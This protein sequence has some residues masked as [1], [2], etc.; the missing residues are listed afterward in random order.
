M[1]YVV[2]EIGVI[3]NH[4]HYLMP[5]IFDLVHS[6]QNKVQEIFGGRPKRFVDDFCSI[7][8]GVAPYAFRS[9]TVLVIMDARFPYIHFCIIIRIDETPAS[10]MMIMWAC[11]DAANFDFVEK[12]ALSLRRHS[13]N[14][15]QFCGISEWSA[16]VNPPWVF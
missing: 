3:V 7:K 1:T 6:H 15:R 12:A 4:V 14:L 9:K 16:V 5:V 10:P 8:K 13:I 11:D 2:V